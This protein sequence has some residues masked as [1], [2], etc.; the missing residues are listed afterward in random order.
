MQNVLLGDS[1]DEITELIFKVASDSSLR[2]K[3]GQG[4]YK[5]YQKCYRSDI[6]IP[7]MLKEIESCCRRTK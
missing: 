2:E 4:G 6:V 3:I 1:A 7:R 5:T